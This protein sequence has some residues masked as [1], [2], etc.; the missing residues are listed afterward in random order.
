M[1]LLYTL[2]QRPP[3]ATTLLLA[4]QHMLASIGGIVAVPLIVGS[5]INLPAVEIADLINA[6]LLASGIGTIIQCVGFGAI[7]IRL[8]VVMGSSFAFLGVL[9]TIGKTD[10][11]S[12]IMG[13][14][15]VGSF[16]V[17]IASFFMEK[18][19][20]LFPDVVSGVVITLIGLTILPV[21]MNW[22]GD[23]PPGSTDFATLP[24]LFLAMISLG[25]VILVSVYCRGVIA[26]SAIVIGLLGGY[27]VALSMG[28]V[29]LNL[30]S[31]ATWTAGPDLFKYGMTFSWGP[32]LSI[33]LVYIIVVA[34]ATGDFMALAANCQKDLTGK[35]LK[36]GVLGDGITST[37][38][39]LLTA[40]PLAS[41]SQ[42]VGIV[43]ITGVASR[44]VVAATGGLLIIGGMFPKLAALAV[45]IPKPVLGGVGFIMFGMIAY[46][47][48]RMLIK[49][50]DTR[51]NALIICV[52]LAAGLAVT[53]E[54]RLI[55]HLPHLLGEFFH[56]GITTGTIIAV[57]LH[58][59][60]PQDHKEERAVKKQ[61]IAEMTRDEDTHSA[62]TKI[63]DSKATISK[64][65]ATIE[66]MRIEAHEVMMQQEADTKVDKHSDQD[67]SEKKTNHG[68][69]NLMPNTAMK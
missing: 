35:E 62:A 20:K 38:G 22:V 64:A 31:N 65:I 59:I 44:Y 28:M 3:M 41:F 46:A 34:E 47:G 40:M 36:R 52:S 26:A 4:L 7:G 25:I 14:A 57:L 42:N 61:E 68:Q 60:L 15:F 66:M 24:K 29:D 37:I 27:L 1:K 51:R 67:Q 23:A 10:G 5:S 32:I 11:M 58:Q 16:L 69:S 33:S 13:A 39:A 43:G 21:A 45:T 53:I 9:I 54:P 17:I 63:L 48:I 8:P 19:K 50:A 49:A 56:S 30:I 55:Q 12:G 2:N 6:A 18:I